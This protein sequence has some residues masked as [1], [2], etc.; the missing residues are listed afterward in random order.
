M[1]LSSSIDF[2][3]IAK[4]LVIVEI[5]HFQRQ[6][7]LSDAT[8]ACSM[9]A[10]PWHQLQLFQRQHLLT[11]ATIACS[12]TAHPWH[13]LQLFQQLHLLITVTI[14][15]SLDAHLWIKLQPCQLQ[16][17]LEAATATCSM[18]AHPWLKHPSQILKRKESQQMLFK[19]IRHSITQQ[20]TSKRHVKTE[21]L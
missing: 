2:F 1:E 7:L 5:W 19:V 9:V 10:H 17:L 14:T 3:T 18:A 4:T 12:I 15:C 11:A 20:T 16:H 6:H 8:I 21:F 13:Q